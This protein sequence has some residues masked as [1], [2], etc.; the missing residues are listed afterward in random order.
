MLIHRKLLPLVTVLILLFAWGCTDRGTN[1]PPDTPA[2][3]TAVTIASH[4]FTRELYLQIGRNP[5]GN[6]VTLALRAYIPEGSVTPIQGGQVQPVPLLILLAPQDGDEY[7]FFNHGLKQLAD[8]MIA[9]GTIQPMAIVCVPNDQVFGGYFYAGHNP[10]AGYYDELIGGALIEWMRKFDCLNESLPV[11]IGGVGMGAYGAFRAALMHQGMFSSI[12]V[13]DG[14][15]DFDG[16]DGTEGFLELFDDALTEQ[17]LLNEAGWRT[18]FDTSGTWHLSRL[19]IGGA[20]AF[21][22]HDTAIDTTGIVSIK[23]RPTADGSYEE[24]WEIIIPPSQRF[25]INDS[26]TL[27][28]EIVKPDQ[29]DFDFHFPFD[30]TGALYPLIW[31]MWLN[32][33]LEKILLDK[34]SGA[35]RGVKMWFGTSPEFKFG[36][37]RQQTLSWIDWLRHGPVDQNQLYVKEYTGY[38]GNPATNDRYV[39][40]I[41][42]DM[43]IFHSKCFEEH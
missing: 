42:R 17:G 13:T 9:D 29:Y 3:K 23:T 14:P 32:N 15:L 21:S 37:Y 22:P 2:S 24:Y 35:L 33:N 39:Y 12:S 16:P 11:G 7:Y 30:N 18:K 40:D 43:L 26:T 19:F 25:T 10:G 31:N 41:I 1:V 36:N 34:G 38:P 4:D 8:E 28:T 6:R 5:A 27:I 20:L